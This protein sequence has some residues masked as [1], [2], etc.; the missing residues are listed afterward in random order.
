MTETPMPEALQR[1]VA[2][3]SRDL[4]TTATDNWLDIGEDGRAAYRKYL[5]RAWTARG[6]KKRSELA[7]MQL[8]YPSA[9][10]GIDGGPGVYIGGL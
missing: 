10:S 8:C 4:R 2:G 7:A 9:G 5:D 1:A 3:L 6:L